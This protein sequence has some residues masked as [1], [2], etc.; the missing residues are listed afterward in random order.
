MQC[1]QNIIYFTA[2]RYS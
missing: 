1:N 2:Q